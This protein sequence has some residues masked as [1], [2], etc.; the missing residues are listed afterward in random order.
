MVIMLVLLM[1]LLLVRL[2]GDTDV[3]GAGIGFGSDDVVGDAVFD[4]GVAVGGFAGGFA[5]FLFAA[6]KAA[7]SA[8]SFRLI[9]ATS[10]SLTTFLCSEGL[11]I[12][13]VF[14]VSS[15]S[16]HLLASSPF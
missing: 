13:T 15:Q 11:T 4:G 8:S 3:A 5:P 6:A 12:L 2:L 1:A 10:L 14:M 7:A 9:S 16:F